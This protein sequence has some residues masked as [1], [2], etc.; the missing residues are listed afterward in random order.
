MPGKTFPTLAE[1]NKQ[2]EL[3]GDAPI[4]AVLYEAQKALYDKRQDLAS[5][6][7]SRYEPLAG[8]SRPVFPPPGSGAVSG[9]LAAD[10]ARRC[11]RAPGRVMVKIHP[12]FINQINRRYKEEHGN[13]LAALLR[14]FIDLKDIAGGRDGKLT[15]A[16]IKAELCGPGEDGFFLHKIGTWRG[17]RQKLDHGAGLFWERY[18][19]KRG[20]KTVRLFSRLNV[21]KA[22]FGDDIDILRGDLVWMPLEDITGSLADF[23]AACFEAFLVGRKNPE[24]P[25]SK[26]AIRKSTGMSERAQWNYRQK[27]GIVAQANQAI[28]GPYSQDLRDKAANKYGSSVYKVTDWEGRN[29]KKGAELLARKIADCYKGMTL[30]KAEG[31]AKKSINK[32]I[33][34]NLYQVNNEAQVSSFPS[35]DCEVETLAP[36]LYHSDGK[37]AW[38]AVSSQRADIALYP[39]TSHGGYMPNSRKRVK[40]SRVNTW[41][42]AAPVGEC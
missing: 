11:Q 4:S 23:R 33:T 29:G 24:R 3:D 32:A 37:Q 10:A 26:P 20:R 13:D 27:R 12:D 31:G 40:F 39:A 34:M 30:E 8:S 25:I 17:I 5:A 16:T 7:P 15:E 2:R 41:L 1:L 35:A 6:D 18:R 28:I 42:M 9:K 19:D 36:K 14:M 22:L 38:N 21:L